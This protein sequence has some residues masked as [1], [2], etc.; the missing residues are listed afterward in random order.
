MTMPSERTN[1][2]LRTE[3]FL[4]D[5]Q[6]PK[7]YPRVPKEVRMEAGRL[8]RHYPSEYHMMSITRSFEELSDTA[9]GE[10][11]KLNYKE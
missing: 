10:I 6:D 3:R 9:R 11:D 1:A 4:R 5:L 2:V 8:L 7:L